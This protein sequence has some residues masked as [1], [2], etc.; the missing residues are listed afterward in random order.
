MNNQEDFCIFCNM[1]HTHAR[2][3]ILNGLE[4]EQK[5]KIEKVMSLAV[6]AIYFK[7]NAD[8]LPALNNIVNTL[9]PETY[10]QLQVNERDAFV[11]ICLKGSDDDKN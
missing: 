1:E 7:D 4:K 9:A 3:C 10:Q 5:E 8:Y 6:S 2:E 11:R